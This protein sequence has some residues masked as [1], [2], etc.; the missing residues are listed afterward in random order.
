M[1]ELK[2]NLVLIPFFQDVDREEKEVENQGLQIE[3]F[4]FFLKE[5][6]KQKVVIHWSCPFCLLIEN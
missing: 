1:D 5:D 3:S 2:E 6:Y 4:F